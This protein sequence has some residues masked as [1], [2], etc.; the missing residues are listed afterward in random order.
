MQ[1]VRIAICRHARHWFGAAAA[2]E[3][4]EEQEKGLLSR[5]TDTVKGSVTGFVQNAYSWSSQGL[6]AAATRAAP[7]ASDGDE[8]KTS[9]RQL[10]QNA[11]W[12]VET[13]FPEDKVRQY[14]DQAEANGS[15]PSMEQVCL[16]I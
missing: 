15:D 16:L 5:A 13:G 8:C 6:K 9:T 14:V 12:L 7:S 2:E 11:D 1:L 3:R 10:N 4:H